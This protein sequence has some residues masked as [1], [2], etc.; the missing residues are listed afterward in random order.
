MTNSGG[1]HDDASACFHKVVFNDGCLQSLKCYW[2]CSYLNTM[3][4]EVFAPVHF[5]L[6]GLRERQPDGLHGRTCGD[7]KSSSQDSPH[8]PLHIV[9]PN[10]S[11]TVYTFQTK[12]VCTVAMAK[13]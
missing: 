6:R 13:P 7:E 8:K 4:I 11:T 2:S 10:V 1:G 12:L 9:C 3:S 5:V